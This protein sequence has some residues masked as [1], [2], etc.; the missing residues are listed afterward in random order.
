MRELLF[1]LLC[2]ISVSVRAQYLE[3]YP[4]SRGNGDQ[5]MDFKN[6]PEAVRQFSALLEENPDDLELRYKLGKSYIYA[7]INKKKAVAYLMDLGHYEDNENDFYETL[8]KAYFVN[9]EFDKAKVLYKTMG[10]SAL[11]ETK[12]NEYNKF[13]AQCDISKKMMG[14]PVKVSFENLG[15]NVNSKAPDFFPI[16]TLDESSVVFSTKRDGVVGNL[17][18]YDGYKT[19]DIYVTKHKRNKYSKARSVGNPNTYGDEYSAGRSSLG[20]FITY[21]VNSEDQFNDI[22]VSEKG[23]RS[24]MPP[25]EFD[26][27]DVNGK[28]DELGSTLSDDGRVMYFASNR[29]GGEG[30]FDI[31]YLQRLPN[32]SWS[33]IKNIGAPINTSGDEMYPCFGKG[34][35]VL[36][37]ASNGHEGMG[38]LDLFKSDAGN[39]PNTWEIP[40]NLGYPIN[41]PNDDKNISFAEN[42]RYAYMSKRFDDSFGDLDIYRLTFLDKK[43]A[44]T[45]VSGRV[46]NQDSVAL[47]S[48]VQI[49]VFYEETGHFAGRYIM[50]KTNGK[51][52]AILAPGRYSIQISNVGGY[53]DYSELLIVRGKNDQARKTLMDIVLEPQ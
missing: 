34:E 12:Q 25:K 47:N 43:D 14:S 19:S 51:Y 33:A 26:S 24:Y 49:E 37:F 18:S 30:G 45:L 3:Q 36:Y 10:D 50:N 40:T 1:V 48:E 5:M 31:Y 41:T 7:D 21:T 9:Y 11:T 8:A 23:R 13:I 53:K 44:Y 38:G 35:N 39:R 46:L 15:K 29:E 17:Y 2:C 4:I 20:S 32:D 28:K 27:E 6:W 22:F 52:S 16:V 42:E